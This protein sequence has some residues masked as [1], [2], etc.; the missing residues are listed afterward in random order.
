MRK[1]REIAF[2]QIQPVQRCEL[3]GR[4]KSLTK[5]HLIPR[6]VHSKKRY[7]HRH[8]KTALQ[9]Q[10]LMLCRQCHDGIHDLIPD[11]KELADRFHSKELLLADERIQKHVAWVKKQK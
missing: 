11:E 3:C 5:H 6:A 7:L 4:I 10:S 9:H 8:G 1:A 2:P